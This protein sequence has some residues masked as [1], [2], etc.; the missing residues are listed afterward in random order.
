MP[1]IWEWVNDTQVR[2]L[3]KGKI[4]LLSSMH[5]FF[6]AF[7]QDDFTRADLAISRAVTLAKEVDEPWYWAF[8]SHW[9]LQTWLYGLGMIARSLDRVIAVIKEI[10]LDPIY[11]DL[12]QRFCLYDDLLRCYLDTDPVGF[13]DEIVKTAEYLLQMGASDYECRRCIMGDLI[14]AH[15]RTGEFDHALDWCQIKQART[16]TQRGEV[17]EDLAHISFERG[18]NEEAVRYFVQ[19]SQE[20]KQDGRPLYAA[21]AD[22]LQ[23]RALVRLGQLDEANRLLDAAQTR[24]QHAKNPK[25]TWMALEVRGEL[26]MSRG[27]YG[28]AAAAF[29]SALGVMGTLGWLRREAEIALKRVEALA[30]T[31]NDDDWVEAFQDAQ[32][33]VE[34]LK[35]TDLRPRLDSLAQRHT[36]KNGEVTT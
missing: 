24:I 13:H 34:R 32:T 26:L 28:A 18:D 22:V 3:R 35:S 29:C 14:A 8:C 17:A 9:Q 5:T 7:E 11:A 33:R 30:H 19:A 12:P 1:S 31:P 2:L 16:R 15:T 6:E 36:P 25:R 21:G 20:Y 4:D 27:N 10:E 23:A